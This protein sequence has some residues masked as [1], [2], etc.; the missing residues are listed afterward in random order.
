MQRSTIGD[1]E[2]TLWNG[3]VNGTSDETVTFTTG[4]SW[5]IVISAGGMSDYVTAGFDVEPAVAVSS[6]PAQYLFLG[7]LPSMSLDVAGHDVVTTPSASGRR[8]GLC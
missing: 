7:E 3:L 1:P 6:L 4:G 8:R 2:E 5:E